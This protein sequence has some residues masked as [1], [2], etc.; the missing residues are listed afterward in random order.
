M[1]TH[2]KR[3]VEN[4]KKQVTFWVDK[5]VKEKMTIFF[6]GDISRFLRNCINKGIQDFN[7][8]NEMMYYDTRKKRKSNENIQ[9]S[10]Y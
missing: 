3:V 10:I 2:K 4:G 6:N 5:E 9:P 1:I 8:F 7:F